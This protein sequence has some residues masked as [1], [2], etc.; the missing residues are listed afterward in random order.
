MNYVDVHGARIRYHESGDPAAPPVVLLHGIGRSLEDW[1]AQHP[2]LDA[3]HRVISIDM[4]GFGLSQRLP[5]STNLTALSDGVWATLDALG[6]TRPVHLMGNSLGGAVSMQMLVDDPARVSTLTLANSAGFGKEVTI[7][8]RM[9]AVPG[10]GRRLLARIDKISA[11]RLERTVFAD[12]AMVTP[13]RIAMAIKVAR[14][15]DFAA[16]YLEV[17]QALGGFRGIAPRWRSELLPRVAKHA[18][19]TLLLWGDRDRILPHAHLAA[20]RS[21]FPEASWHLFPNTG[22]MPQIERPAEFNELVR[23]LLAKVPA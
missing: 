18:K 23:P 4:P 6:E 9:L 12:R 21:A 10:L 22:H 11:P 7:A 14:Q 13:E 8:L 5:A 19:P 1:D 17:A 3:D 16:V 20:A 15:P 2:L